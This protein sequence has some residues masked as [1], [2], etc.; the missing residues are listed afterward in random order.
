[1]TLTDTPTAFERLVADDVRK[2]ADV[3]AFSGAKVE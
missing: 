1:M 3:V 2:W